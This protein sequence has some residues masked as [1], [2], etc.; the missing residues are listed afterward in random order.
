MLTGRRSGTRLTTIVQV[1]GLLALVAVAL[2]TPGFL[3]VPSFVSLATSVSLIGCVAIGM[4]FI[5]LSGN[6]MSYSLGATTAAAAMLYCALSDHGLVLAISAAVATAVIVTALQGLAIGYFRA[7]AIIVSIAALALIF[8]VAE[9]VSGGQTV[10]AGNDALAFLKGKLLE[11]PLPFI[12]FMAAA[13][14]GQG[15]LS[16]TRFG[17]NVFLV[18]SNPRAAEA[19]GVPSA[20]T[21]TGVY[22]LSGLFTGLSALLLA[23][24]YGSGSME[25]GVGYDYSAIGATLV[26]GTAIAGGQGS[27]VRTVFGVIVVCTIDTLLVLRGFETQ[28]KYFFTGLVVLAAM[29]LQSRGRG[30]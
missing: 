9:N 15:V 7:N 27:V 21:I 5:T 30:A 6:I 22:A 14:I 26:G 24:R 12:V 2:Q 10:Y 20:R 18:G 3:T 25:F 17:A 13:A 4:T 19:T 29:L 1:T 11:V 28:Y 16:W 8:G 23:G